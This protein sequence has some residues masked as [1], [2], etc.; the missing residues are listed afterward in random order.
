MNKLIKNIIKDIDIELMDEF[1]RNFERKGFFDRKW[2]QTKLQNR[3]GSLMMRSGA[4]RRSIKSRVIGNRIFYNS[5]VPYANLQNDGGEIRVT[6]KMK[7]FFWAMF[8]KANNA[9]Q[10]GSKKR[11]K[12][13]TQ[14]AEQWRNLALMKTG[15]KITIQQRQFIGDHSRVKAVVKEVMDDH[16]EEINAYYNAKIQ[17]NLK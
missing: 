11:K 1:D 8:Y 3:R 16:L 6:N 17:N 15:D 7:S 9:S 5:S 10:S 12:K 13:L 14:E 4:L 2:P